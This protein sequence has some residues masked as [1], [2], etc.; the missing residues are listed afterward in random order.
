MA[1]PSLHG[2]DLLN[3]YPQSSLDFIRFL[4]KYYYKLIVLGYAYV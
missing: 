1:L 4:F 2:H 3:S